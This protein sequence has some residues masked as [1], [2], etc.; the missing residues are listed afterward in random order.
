[1]G[2]Y[3]ILSHIGFTIKY[4]THSNYYFFEKKIMFIS[5]YRRRKFYYMYYLKVC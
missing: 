4:Q 2:A 5:N 1:M 3:D